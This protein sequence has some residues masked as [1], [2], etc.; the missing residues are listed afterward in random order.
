MDGVNERV[1][2]N[3]GKIFEEFAKFEETMKEL[4]FL[5]SIVRDIEC[6]KR[7]IRIKKYD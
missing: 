2:R 3:L 5:K 6:I 7:M 4:C 1:S